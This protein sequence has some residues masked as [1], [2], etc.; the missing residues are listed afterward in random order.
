M[1]VGYRKLNYNC[2]N[3]KTLTAKIIAE[4]SNWTKKYNLDYG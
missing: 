4:T 1:G 3:S 2:C